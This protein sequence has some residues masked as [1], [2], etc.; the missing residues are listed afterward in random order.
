MVNE[1]EEA[2]IFTPDEEEE[3]EELMELFSKESALYQIYEKRGWL[4]RLFTKKILNMDKNALYSTKQVAEILETE[5]YVVNNKRR[6]FISYINPR[7]IGESTKNWKHDY[8]AVFKLKMIDGLTGA[9]G[10]FTLQEIKGILYGGGNPTK[11]DD[12]DYTSSS[13]TDHFVRIIN[14]YEEQLQ[15]YKEKLAVLAEGELEKAIDSIIE[16]KLEQQLASLPAPQLEEDAIDEL[17]E[18][19]IQQ[20]QDKEQQIKKEV[21]RYY[22][23]ILSPE[24]NITEKESIIGKL[25]KLEENNPY[26]SSS[27]RIYVD[28]ANDRIRAFKQ[29]LQESHVMEVKEK[30]LHYYKTYQDTTLT[31]HARET[32][33]NQLQELMV[34]EPELEFE[35]RSYVTQIVIQKEK[36]KSKGFFSRL[37]G[38]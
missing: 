36:Q 5:P 31:E 10:D 38:R 9:G 34:K 35:I 29:D 28:F 23:E 32:A 6:E 12:R 4:D 33:F 7:M 22:Q 20:A 30:A 3:R 15:S 19:K 16:R 13:A 1:F 14:E 8:I 21:I 24:T 17:V 11:V 26:F 27:I 25:E 2:V 18:Q 37:L